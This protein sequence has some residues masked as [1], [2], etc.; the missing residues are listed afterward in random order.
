MPL[1]S[2]E[3]SYEGP[4][5]VLP[6]STAHDRVAAILRLL[7][8][9]S[10]GQA[11][12]AR[13]LLSSFLRHKLIAPVL[14][15]AGYTLIT[16]HRCALLEGLLFNMQRVMSVLKTRRS[17]GEHE[18]RMIMAAAVTQCELDY[19][20]DGPLADAYDERGEAVCPAPPMIPPAEWRRFLKTELFLGTKAQ[21][22][23]E[24]IR[25]AAAEGWASGGLAPVDLRPTRAVRSDSFNATE[26]GQQVR[27]GVVQLC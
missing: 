4:A 22:T 6:S 17:R 25:M 21:L 19:L 3:W 15:E 9:L 1:R 26:A 7:H 18:Q 14:Q 13:Q 8:G 16:S 5:T 20:P 10:S 11:L 27:V 23:A 12:T 24:S 2:L